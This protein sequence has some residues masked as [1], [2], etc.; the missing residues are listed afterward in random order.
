M[1]MHI[2]QESL[3]AE[4]PD[5]VA[6]WLQR[7]EKK[8]IVVGI[9]GLG[10]VG[11]PLAEAFVNRGV[12]VLGFEVDASKVRAIQADT[13][14]IRHISSERIAVMNQSGRLKTTM[15]LA[16]LSEP[17]ALLLCV[18][19]P[20]NSDRG[21]DLKYVV[22]SCEMIGPVL[23]RGQLVVLE[24][25][26]WPGTTTE[27]MIPILER[28]SG[29]KAHVDFAIAY[30]PEREDPGNPLFSTNSIPK[31]VGAEHDHERQMAGIMYDVITKTVPVRDLRT[32]EAVKLVENI[33]R[34]VNIGLVNELKQIFEKMDIDVWEVIEA[35]KT[36]PFGFQAF[37]PGP[38]L[39]GHCIPID[40]FYLTWKAAQFGMPTKMISLAG[41]ITEALPTM[42]IDA[43]EAALEK[44]SEKSLAGAKV[45]VVGLAY[46]RD[47]DDMRESPSIHLIE[48]LR[49]RGAIVEYH[50][51]FIPETGPSLDHPEIA[52][53]VSVALDEATLAGFD[54]A[55]IS[56]DHAKIDYE[57]LVKN[58]PF[59][60][61]TRNAT[62]ALHGNYRH[63][64]VMA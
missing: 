15:D 43:V 32:A 34:L 36:K 18:P 64:I 61:D 11:L 37:Y 24:S 1:N 26:T 8:E 30:S 25:T 60:V 51:P 28:L 63:K 54:C 62:R 19:T 27:V 45:L 23:R 33:Y 46:K 59:V 20:L 38:G 41:D 17:D 48:I 21:P 42:T 3:L 49:A 22:S 16:R 14:Y 52:N 5:F 57:I 39:G 10:Y 47:I 56:T 58:L 44:R 7:A 50:D 6:D 12:H 31:V 13:S 2:N 55:L 35:A 9:L 29:L 53:M 40:P 4:T